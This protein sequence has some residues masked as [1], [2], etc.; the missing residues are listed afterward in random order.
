MMDLVGATSWWPRHGRQEK[1]CL[2]ENAKEKAAR[3]MFE[4]KQTKERCLLEHTC[5]NMRV[6]VSVDAK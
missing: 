4:S 5:W 3:N 2:P 1:K 6:A